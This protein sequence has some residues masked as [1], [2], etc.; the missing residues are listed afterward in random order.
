MVTERTATPDIATV[1]Q[2]YQ[3]EYE[4]NLFRMQKGIEL[5]RAPAPSVG[6]TPADVIYERG[7]LKLLH[8]RPQTETQQPLPV[9][10]VMSL[11][12]KPYIFDLYPG[13]SFVEYLLQRGLDVYLIDWGTPRPEDKRLTLDDY[14]Q[15]LMERC[16]REMQEDCGQEQFSM[17]GYCLGGGLSLMYAGTHTDGGLRNLISMTTPVD[18]KKMGMQTLMSD[19][20][21]FDVDKLVDTFGNVPPSVIE[22]SFDMLRPLQRY[23][24]YVDL[25]YGLLDSEFVQSFRAL[26]RWASDQIPFAGEAFRQLTKELSWGNK[27]MTGELMLGGKRCDLR[28]IN[29]SFLAVAAEHDHIVPRAASEPLLGL[30]GSDDKQEIV[31]RG[32]HVSLVAGRSAMKRLWPAVGDWLETRSGLETGSDAS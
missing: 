11:V 5:A 2:R 17:L 24:K 20:R 27:M 28:E 19:P 13:N 7:T 18:Y 30:I 10:M 4:R 8:Y 23:T 1:Q 22:A 3:Q 16:V 32:G 9:L 15:D 12:S 26:D 14:T 29:C 31:L 21:Y 25:W 6:T